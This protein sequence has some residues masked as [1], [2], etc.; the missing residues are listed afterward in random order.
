MND[1][2]LNVTIK[3]NG[4]VT[5]DEEQIIIQVIKNLLNEKLLFKQNNLIDITICKR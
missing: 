3:T 4:C 1:I 2:N 5:V